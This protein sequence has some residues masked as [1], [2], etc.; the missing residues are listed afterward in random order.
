MTESNL[1]VIV[2]G[3]G[4]GGLALAQGLRRDN[5][6]VAVYER[7][8]SPTSRR[9]GYRLRLNPEGLTALE[10]LLPPRLNQVVWATCSMPRPSLIFDAGLDP[11][12]TTDPGR[13]AGN[14]RNVVV[15]RLTL[16]QILLDGLDDN[17]RFGCECLGYRTNADGTV[18]ALFRDG[19]QATGDVL[20]GAD[21]VNSAVRQQYLP[22]A[23][24]MDT[25]VRIV[26]GRFPLTPD[27]AARIPEHL[28]TLYTGVSGPDRQHIGIAPVQL[29]RPFE[30]TVA[31]LA[32]GLRLTDTEDYMMCLFAARAELLPRTDAELRDATGY[33]LREMV[34]TMVGDWHPMVG[35]IVDMWTPAT[36]FPLVLRSSV[37]IGP[38]PTTA[39]TLLGDAIHA[40]SP[41]VG[42]GANIA[43]RDAHLL[44]T[45]LGKIARGAD[46]VAAVR[47]YETA[48]IEY[49]FDAVRTSAVYGE[50]RMGQHPLVL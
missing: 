32:P 22:H 19:S 30:H 39:V 27:I 2:I 44:A 43:L 47:D 5:I 16:R 13:G 9:Q 36:V 49:G 4:L 26:Y 1:R 18:T 42:I 14:D 20:V 34:S 46:R 7:D 45:Q 37:P 50:Q 17:V 40:M 31:R 38:W 15:N 6:D 10:D 23:R 29:R 11:L 8:E 41:A 3:A 33:Q 25:G 24:V 28:F 12:P 48:M 21:G 35:S